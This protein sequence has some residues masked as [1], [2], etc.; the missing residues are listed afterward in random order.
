MAK[1]FIKT[2]IC[3]CLLTVTLVGCGKSKLPEEQQKKF[4]NSVNNMLADRKSAEDIET[5]I[6]KKIKQLDTQ[7]SSDVINAYI[8]ALYQENSN[9]LNKVTMEQGDLDEIA[10]KLNIDVTNKKNISKIE[11]G[12]IK[13]LLQDIDKRHLILKKEGKQYYISVDINYVLSKYGKYMADDLKAFTE[14]RKKE[15]SKNVFNSENETFDIEE[16]ANRIVFIEK[17]LPKWKNSQFKENWN[18]QQEYYYSILF[19]LNHDF[20]KDGDKLNN[21]IKN[22]FEK[23]IKD[24]PDTEFE[25]DMKSYLN[26]VSKAQGKIDGSV[27]SYTDDII[28]SKFPHSQSSQINKNMPSTSEDETTKNNRSK[29]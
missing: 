8:F 23:A 24:N 6:N 7:Y 13:G 9:M 27:I 11:D 10:K 26:I 19:S 3:A 16:I 2:L 1:R 20:F 29:E 5:E 14:F 22:K 21:A 18:G 28:K 17:E 25:K 15:E 4:V 12:V